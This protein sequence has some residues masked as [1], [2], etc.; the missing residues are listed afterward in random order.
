MTDFS[1]NYD[2]GG[3]CAECDQSYSDY[4]FRYIPTGQWTE[5]V[6]CPQGHVQFGGLSEAFFETGYYLLS[7]SDDEWP[8]PPGHC[9][10]LPDYNA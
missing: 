1:D 9:L 8:H 2:E 10:R 4:Q 3:Y 7:V 5:S 6:A